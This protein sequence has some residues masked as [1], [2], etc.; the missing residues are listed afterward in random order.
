M[1]DKT[2]LKEVEEP[3][4]NEPPAGWGKL[5][6]LVKSRKFWAALAGLMVVLVKGAWP[7]LPLD[8]D[9][10]KTLLLVL[11]AYIGGTALEDGLRARGG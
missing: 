8:D 10:H 7:D 6:L 9:T 4:A 3:G 1:Q 5:G 11:A 2:Q